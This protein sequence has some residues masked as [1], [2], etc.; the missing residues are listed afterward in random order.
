MQK[1]LSTLF[2][3]L[4][5]PMVAFAQV[6]ATYVGPFPS[7]DTLR[8]DGNGGHGLAVDVEGK[9]WIQG[10]GIAPATSRL[11]LETPILL[12]AAAVAP[13]TAVDVRQIF[14]Y[15]A[16][17]TPADFSPITFL[18]R[19]GVVVDTLGLDLLGFA[20]VDGVRYARYDPMSGRGMRASV[21]G[22]IIYIAQGDRLLALS[23][24]TGELIADARPVPGQAGVAPGVDALGNVYTGVVVQAAGRP[25]K[26]FDAQL[27]EINPSAIEAPNGFSRSL[28]V[29]RDGL[30]IYWGGYS[31]P[32]IAMYT[33][34][35]DL[36]DFDQTPVEI[37]KGFR[38]E[39]ITV[40]N[41]G[42]LWAS[43]GSANDRPN[44]YPDLETTYELQTWYA[45]D[46]AAISAENSNPPALATLM[47]DGG[48]AG[49]PRGLAI[50]QDGTRAYVTQFNQAAPQV[51]EFSLPAI[52][53]ILN[54]GE[55]PSTFALVN[56]FPNPS[57]GRVQIQFGVTETANTTLR[58]YDTLGRE[59]ATLVN[60]TLT[61]DTY[62]YTFDG[63]SLPAGLYVYRLTSGSQTASGVMT[64]VR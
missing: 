38:S 28:D 2:A 40:M 33:R 53:S 46:E 11:N 26:I 29:S 6:Q 23:A 8:L 55:V 36:S 19:D 42:I 14:V 24:R 48:G 32:F 35:D 18:R 22:E 25:I 9:V 54:T 1:T 27:N 4:L 10:F 30:R 39:S 61:P 15:N 59:V 44:Q 49:R 7:P 17:G 47:W 34:E 58:V 51:Q 16:D 31:L 13:V 43:A 60:Q 21:D 63:T 37:L 3:L 5:L 45:F 56:A 41:G 52:T 64:L 12:G 20:E 57:E 62:V 50:T